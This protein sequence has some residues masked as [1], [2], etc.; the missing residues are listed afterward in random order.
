MRGQMILNPHMEMIK[1]ILSSILCLILIFIACYIGISIQAQI[2]K[3]YV[4]Q[5]YEKH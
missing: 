1:K 3:E 2:E 4:S 5:A